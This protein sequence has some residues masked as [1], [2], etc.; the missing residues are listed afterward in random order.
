MK[1]DNYQ[2]IL[3]NTIQN[4]LACNTV[5][6]VTRLCKDMQAENQ[7]SVTADQ[8]LYPARPFHP[9]MMVKLER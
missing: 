6:L 1:Q 5:R 9:S 8:P 2:Q 3:K 4:P 7:F